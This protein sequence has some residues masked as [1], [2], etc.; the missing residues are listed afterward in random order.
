MRRFLVGPSPYRYYKNKWAD[1]G[2]FGQNFPFCPDETKNYKYDVNLDMTEETMRTYVAE[3]VG[4][5]YLTKASP[6]ESQ[7]TLDVG[8]AICF[9]QTYRIQEKII[10]PCVIRQMCKPQG[11]WAFFV[12]DPLCPDSYVSPAVSP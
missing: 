12:I 9:W 4:I 6:E 5:P 2:V 7:M 11:Y 8:V 3:L 10:I 1:E